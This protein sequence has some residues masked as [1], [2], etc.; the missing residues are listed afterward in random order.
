MGDGLVSVEW[1]VSGQELHADLAGNTPIM[2]TPRL[3]PDFEVSVDINKF[4]T[5]LPAQL[6]A[7]YQ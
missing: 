3:H 1:E 2:V 6:A 5:L 4:I 7:E